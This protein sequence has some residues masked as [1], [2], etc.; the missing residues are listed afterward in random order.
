M[1]AEDV[2]TTGAG[3]QAARFE[4]HVAPHLGGLAANITPAQ[5]ALAVAINAVHH[6]TTPESTSASEL[7]L[8][9]R[10]AQLFQQI[11][12]L[13]QQLNGQG[14]KQHKKAPTAKVHNTQNQLPD[15]LAIRSV[16]LWNQ[17]MQLSQQ[18]AS[19]RLE[20]DLAEY[21][22]DPATP[23]FVDRDRDDVAAAL[24]SMHGFHGSQDP[25]D[26][27]DHAS[28]PKKKKWLMRAKRSQEDD[29]NADETSSS[30]DSL[31]SVSSSSE[32]SS[33]PPHKVRRVS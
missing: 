7:M 26:E 6:L 21:I 27:A 10:S 19:Q 33:L 22:Q 15:M 13:S 29:S 4:N 3:C 11:I 25:T 30:H 31:S 1:M 20:Q 2:V 23:K 9:I 32:T 18:L 14:Q 24:I 12:E 17:I 28:G 8:A 5:Q 16:Q